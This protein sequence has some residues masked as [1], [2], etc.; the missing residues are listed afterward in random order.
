MAL[1]LFVVLAD[2]AF[3]SAVLRSVRFMSRPYGLCSAL[4][5]VIL[6]SLYVL[7]LLMGS[8]TCVLDSPR[9]EGLGAYTIMWLCLSR[10]CLYACIAHE[11]EDKKETHAHTE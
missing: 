7:T 4:V 10:L 6:A 2:L 9:V 1:Q 5:L 11:V 3:L 8:Q